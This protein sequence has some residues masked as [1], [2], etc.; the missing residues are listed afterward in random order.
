MNWNNEITNR[1]RMNC[2]ICNRCSNLPYV[3]RILFISKVIIKSVYL[4]L[5]CVNCIHIM[6]LQNQPELCSLSYELSYYNY[7]WVYLM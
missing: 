5:L 4:L 3:K 1:R 7:Y 2:L 6:N